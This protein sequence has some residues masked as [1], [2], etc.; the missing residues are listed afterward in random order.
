MIA[1]TGGNPFLLEFFYLS[2]AIILLP[3]SLTYLK[4][5]TVDAS[6]TTLINGMLCFTIHTCN[7]SI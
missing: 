4:A 7:A 2:G 1:K 6:A 3:N 5:T